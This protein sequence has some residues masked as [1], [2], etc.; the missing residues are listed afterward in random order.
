VEVIGMQATDAVP[1]SGGD[2]AAPPGN[3]LRGIAAPG[4]AVCTL[5]RADELEGLAKLALANKPVAAG[6][7]IHEKMCLH[8]DA[9]RRAAEAAASRPKLVR[10]AGVGDGHLLEGALSNLGAAEAQL[11][12]F[13][14]A[15]FVLGQMPSLVKLVRCNLGADDPRR[16]ALERVARRVS[17]LDADPPVPAPRTGP[18][19]GDP[20]GI[21]LA[22]RHVIA[23]ATRAASSAALRQQVRL[24][25]FRRVLAVTTLAMTLLGIALAVVGAVRPELVPLCFAPEESGKATVVCPVG[26][27]S[28]FNTV[29]A[30][31][32]AKDID[33]YVSDTVTRWDLTIVLLVGLT[34]AALAAAT[35]I[36]GIRG[37]SERHGIPVALA[38]LKLP[39]GAVTAFLG[40]LLMRGE[41]VPGLSALDTSAQILAWAIVFGYAQELFTRLVDK[42]GHTLLDGVRTA[43]TTAPARPAGG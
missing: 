27:S 3:S 33:D 34:A 4:W 22:E 14:D 2:I 8:I 7:D 20:A 6:S 39:T 19:A 15:P 24:R 9:A 31:P 42:Q 37:S 17:V 32:A 11:L 40:L 21:S 10:A 43:D 30:D 29:P 13:A 35:A 18:G 36:R 41:F 23:A 16:Q 1:V 38:L 25:S 12:D 5:T 28:E 26:Q